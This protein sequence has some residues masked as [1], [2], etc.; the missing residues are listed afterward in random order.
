MNHLKGVKRIEPLTEEQVMSLLVQKFRAHMGI[1]TGYAWE[2]GPYLKRR[3]PGAR[4]FDL[5]FDPPVLRLIYKLPLLENIPKLRLTNLVNKLIDTGDWLRSQKLNPGQIEKLQANI[6]KID[7]R[8]ALAGT[9]IVGDN[10]YHNF[11]DR[12]NKRLDNEDW[13]GALRLA[14]SFRERN[15]EAYHYAQNIN[16]ALR[17]GDERG[18]ARNVRSLSHTTGTGR[19]TFRELLKPSVYYTLQEAPRTAQVNERQRAR[20]AWLPERRRRRQA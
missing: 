5:V 4:L 9:L 6:G 15:N 2:H 16:K 1:E 20:Y 7:R 8:L 18:L 10:K 3:L 11:T 19:L 13:N 12:I 14:R 17:L